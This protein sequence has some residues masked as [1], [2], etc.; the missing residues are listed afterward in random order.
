MGHCIT[1]LVLKGDYDR[2]V[3]LTF[4]LRGIELG[5][6]LHM[7]FVDHYY[8]AYW[9]AKLGATGYLDTSE[10]SMML[11][12]GEAVMAELVQKIAHTRF[13]TFAIIMTD[14]F[15]GVGEQFAQVYQGNALANSNI[16]SISK[17][18]EWLG[19]VPK[20]KLDAF[21]TI[22]LSEHRSNP[23]YLDKFYDLADEL[24]V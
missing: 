2:E 6:G 16:T 13:V 20:K 24:G 4:D 3:A 5:F 12:P 23:E 15:G 22:G 9:Q 10:K 21:D 8:S 19:V 7:F 11:Y 1:A 17:A 14:Y 18:L